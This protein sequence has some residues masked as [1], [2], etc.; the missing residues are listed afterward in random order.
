MLFRSKIDKLSI[1]GVR[2]F[3]NIRSETIQFHTPLTLI[4]GYNGSG[5]TTIIEC[6]KYATTGQLPPNSKGGA[7][8]HDPKLCGEKEVLAQVKLSFKSTTGSKMVVT[9]SL[10]LTVKKTTRSM[11]SLEGSLLMVKDGERT[12]ISSRVAE[13]D[14][15]MPQY[16]GVSEAILDSVIFC[17]QDE[18][19]WPMSEPAA[20]KKKFDEIFEA[21]KYTKALEN[22]KILRKNQNNE[23]S[24]LKIWEETAK[25][26]KDKGERVQKKSIALGD[27]IEHL[28]EQ[29]KI[30]D[31][32]MQAALEE[33]K[34]KHTEANRVLGVV[35]EL[36]AKRER[37]EFFQQ[38]IDDLK[39]NLDELHESD[40]WLET[41]LNQYDQRLWEYEQEEDDYK[42]QYRELQYSIADSRKQLSVKL[43][44]Q[45]RHQAE[46]ENYERQIEAREQLVKEAARLH[47]M[48]GYDGELDDVQIN[49]FIE[50]VRKLSREKDRELERIQNAT[51]DELRQTQSVLTELESRRTAR[52]Q[53]KVTAKQTIVANDKRS[54]AVQSDVDSIIVDEGTMATLDASYK[55]L[56]NQFQIAASEFESANWDKQLQAENSR[57]RDLETESETLRTELVQ[58]TRL[59]KD[60]AQLEFIAKE[61]K[62]RQRSLDTM[63][64]T[65]GEK[66]TS[67]IGSSFQLATI[68]K[69]FQ[70]V[71]EKKN[72]T[73]DD[74]KK[75]QDGIKTDLGE[76]EFKLKTIRATLKKKKE[77]FKTTEAIVLNSI[78]I[79]SK[80]LA[81]LDEYLPELEQLEEDRNT[82][83]KDIDG[84]AH[85]AEYYTNCL[86]TLQEYNKCRLCERKFGDAKEKTAALDRI[87]KLLTKD[88]RSS[89]QK[90]L[91]VLEKDLQMAMSARSKYD[92][93]RS[94]STA[95]IPA[96]ESDLAKAEQLRDALVLKLESQ[97][98]LLNECLSIK[99]DAEALTKT[100]STISRFHHEITGY[101]ADI[102]RISSQQKI[103]G[104]SMTIEEIEERST[105]CGEQIRSLKAKITKIT[106]D[107]DR[108]KATIANLELDLSNAKAKLSNAGHQ[109]DKRQ[110]L[111]SRIEELRE[112]NA[113]QRDIVQRAD[114]DLD[115]LAPEIAKA[116]AL[117][118]D[119]QQQGRAKERE[120]R[121]AQ[122][123]L[124]DTVN[125]F[126]LVESAISSYLDAGGL[127]NL[128]TCERAIRTLEQEQKRMDGEVSQITAK[129][130]DLRKRIDD[131]ERTKRNIADNIN[132]RK[133][134]RTLDS[135]KQ[136]IAQLE[137]RNPT[138]DYERILADAITSD[139]RYQKLLAE[140]GPILG[141]MKA[142]DEELS[143][144]LA[145]WEMDYQHAAQ[146]YREAHIKVETTKAAVEDLAKYGQALDAAIMRYHSLKME[147]INRI[148]G[149]LWQSTYQ[150]TDVDTI[151]IRSENE[152]AS[153]KRSYNYRVC[154]V[155]QDAEMDMRGRCSAGQKVLASI[156]I[157]L[158][159]AECFGVNCGLIALDE[160]TTNL[161][162]DNIRALAESLHAIIR[163]R[164][165]QA[166]F[167]LIVITHDEEFLRYMKCAD[168]CDNYY[169]VSRDDKQKSIIER[170]SIAEV[171]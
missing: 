18:S 131:S 61:L 101:E 30:L 20:L 164:Q 113:Q 132:F 99:R 161:D 149:E 42:T 162:R 111:L 112:N 11:K 15:V 35:N 121:E 139:K 60:R 62:D 115:S 126:N 45:G 49:E 108:A 68:D 44:D 138:T 147:E 81:S 109:I 170:Q 37:A 85:L 89:L 55:D 79:E 166:N 151:L 96:L 93:C 143:R 54:S 31:R 78:L 21:M 2:S 159:L 106:N 17:H 155:K 46:K 168:F 9:R 95:E 51:E 83:R 118:E 86:K 43:A 153:S 23:L 14:Q 67:V 124:T 76:A 125:K 65:Y 36:E 158:A 107:R 146:K 12:T 3:D 123:G 13:L 41:T 135:L 64:A 167:Q 119:A 87:N 100:I 163:A 34:E 32:D 122:K 38:N 105:E 128:A 169:R 40:E 63:I 47:S 142:K 24:K 74:A 52:M 117:Y 28:R 39:A 157:R 144:Y 152:N 4:V 148:A 137:S 127:E 165:Q 160:P 97:D 6:L 133:S 77:E 104:S 66:I 53:D 1:L 29:A 33:A 80:P 8:I 130:N 75:L 22:L 98:S 70:S 48:R 88:A 84:F 129:A 69:E 120:V 26:E 136:Q 156:I 145:E 90:E 91:D 59:A 73:V 19:L 134:I 58:S 103:S 150:G 94:L 50:R 92:I 110:A 25:V 10:Q 57:L 114:S 27:E 56:Q 71:L 5:K 116:K 16:L 82:L 141:S 102:A 171:I 72:Q 140:R 7:F 154:M